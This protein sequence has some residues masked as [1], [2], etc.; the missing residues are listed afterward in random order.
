MPTGPQVSQ[1]LGN[2]WDMS[3]RILT[4]P[5]W[6]T[7]QVMYT[8]LNPKIFI[9]VFTTRLPPPYFH[10]DGKACSFYSLPWHIENTMTHLLHIY[11]YYC[12]LDLVPSDLSILFQSQLVVELSC[13]WGGLPICI[14]LLKEDHLS[15]VTA[16]KQAHKCQT[17]QMTIGYVCIYYYTDVC[18]LFAWESVGR[19]WRV[20]T[21]SNIN[22]CLWFQKPHQT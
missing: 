17:L 2:T 11:Y 7:K 22:G 12:L 21:C 9:R 16:L 19:N 18:T 5:S 13:G 14:T 15:A 10:Q 3:V 4:I 20:V 8:A 1:P 6:G